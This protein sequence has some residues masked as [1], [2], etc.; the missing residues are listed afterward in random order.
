MNSAN[1]SITVFTGLLGTGKATLL[2]LFCDGVK[3]R[4]QMPAPQNQM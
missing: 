1:L 2:A 4:H 3:R